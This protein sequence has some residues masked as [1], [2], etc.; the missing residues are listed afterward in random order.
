MATY[1]EL[2]EL[3]SPDGIVRMPLEEALA[4]GIPEEDARLLAEVGVPVFVD[5]LFTAKV[6][7]D[8]LAYTLVPISAGDDGVTVLALGGPTDADLM[9]YC[10]DLDNGYV[11]LLGLGEEPTAEI[12]NRDLASFVEFL[13]R[14]ALRL[15]HVAGVSDRQADEYTAKLREYLAARDPYAFAAPDSWWNMVF[16]A[17]TD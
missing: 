1:A 2:A 12:V 4:N 7:G 13:Y 15:K 9:R 5:V 8:P 3:F 11:I 14:Y 17:L 6:K 16:G 10:L